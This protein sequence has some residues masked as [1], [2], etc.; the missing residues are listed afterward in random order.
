M[1]E[2]TAAVMWEYTAAVMWEYTAATEASTSNVVVP[3][4]ISATNYS[5]YFKVIWSSDPWRVG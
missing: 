4:E 1:W 5:D 3:V 2:Y